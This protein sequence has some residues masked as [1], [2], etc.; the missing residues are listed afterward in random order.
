[1]R[2]QIKAATMDERDEA[3]RKTLE[4]AK[5]EKRIENENKRAKKTLQI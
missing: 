5:I 4:D 2:L 3:R 1:M